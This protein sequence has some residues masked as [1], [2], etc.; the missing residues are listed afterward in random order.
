VK[1]TK[2]ES[3]TIAGVTT[4]NWEKF[5]SDVDKL[6]HFAYDGNVSASIQMLKKLV[7]EYNPQNEIYKA[8]LKENKYTP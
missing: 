5:E 1:D 2:Y 3:I 8:M 4:V 6:I 7:P